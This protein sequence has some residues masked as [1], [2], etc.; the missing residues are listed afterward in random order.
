MKVKIDKEK[1]SLGHENFYY[2]CFLCS[3][4]KNNTIADDDKFCSKCGSEI[5]WTVNPDIPPPKEP[6][7]KE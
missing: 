7:E 6:K 4:C 5:E 1:D 2:Q 3:N